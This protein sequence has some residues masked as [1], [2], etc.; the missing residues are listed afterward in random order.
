MATDIGKR[1][2]WPSIREIA[3]FFHQ[4]FGLLFSSVDEGL[5]IYVTA[6]DANDVRLL[7]RE[8]AIALETHKSQEA[9][10]NFLLSQG[11]QWSTKS[12]RDDFIALLR[13]L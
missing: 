3:K 7:K 11:A 10:K 8:L 13:S 9:F 1:D 6:L 4:D 12:I 2:R 5:S